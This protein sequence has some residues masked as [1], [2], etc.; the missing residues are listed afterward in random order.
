MSRDRFA[1]SLPQPGQD[2]QNQAHMLP[3]LEGLHSTSP[4]VYTP[5][6]I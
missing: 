6:I 3:G 1:T 4:R 5:T 2:S